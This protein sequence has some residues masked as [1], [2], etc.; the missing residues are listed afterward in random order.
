MNKWFNIIILAALVLASCAKVEVVSSPERAVSFQV[1][2]Y[3]Q[4]TR[5]DG[6]PVSLNSVGITSFSSRA[7]L[8][9]AGLMDQ[10]QNFFGENGETISYQAADNAV[11]WVPSHDYFW[12]KSATSYVNFISWLGGNPAISYAKDG[13][14]WKAT[15][16]WEDVEVSDTDLM[17]ADMAWRYNANVN[18]ATY[19]EYN[20]VAEG[21][22]TLF[23]HALAQVCFLA[24]LTKATDEGVSWS[25]K[26]KS[27]SLSDV[28]GK[29]SLSMTNADP[30]EKKPQAWTFEGWKSLEGSAAIATETEKTFTTTAVDTVLGWTSV[31]PQEVNADME[32]TVTFDVVTTYTTGPVVTEPVTAN[33]ALSDFSA[34]VAEWGMGQR[35][36]YTILINPDTRMITII[37]VGKDWVTEPTYN[38]SVE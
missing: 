15:F 28:Y 17:W 16:A 18:P 5:A 24:G 10:A 19:G 25:V 6:D 7:Y 32:L 31:I 21:V 13:D 27:L 11:T 20:G 38:I 1:G 34:T 29:G 2:S 14:T 9:A 35:I 22:P 23:H 37:P 4:Q 8:H 3:A 33:V 30:G 12:P 26:L 36:T